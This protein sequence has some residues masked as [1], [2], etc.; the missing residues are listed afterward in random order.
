AMVAAGAAAEA[1]AAAEAG[2]SRTVRAAL[3]FEELLEGHDDPPPPEAIEAVKAG[4]RS[5]ARRQLTW[6]RRMEGV[7]LIDR[8]GRDDAEV[9]AEIVSKL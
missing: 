6:M 9:A 7:T 8:G 2:A 1:R 3:G 5:Y 4:H